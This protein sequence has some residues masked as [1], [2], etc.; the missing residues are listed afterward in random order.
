MSIIGLMP[1]Q[2]KDLLAGE[3]RFSK[4]NHSTKTIIWQ[5]IPSV[6]QFVPVVLLSRS[7]FNLRLFLACPIL[8]AC[9]AT[10]ATAKLTHNY[11]GTWQESFALIRD[12]MVYRRNC[13]MVPD[14]QSSFEFTHN[15]E[16][17]HSVQEVTWWVTSCHLINSE[18]THLGSLWWHVGDPGHP[19]LQIW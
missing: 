11:D 8:S 1:H 16:Y 19:D 7:S 9:W 14:T 2:S 5:I 13:N 15:T 4:D 12:Y 3:Q 17:K 6:L 10:S 18:F